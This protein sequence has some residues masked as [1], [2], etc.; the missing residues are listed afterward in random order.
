[1]HARTWTYVAIAAAA[2][3]TACRTGFRVARFTTNEALYAAGMREFGRQNW[4]NA[5]AAF[6]K[7]TTD[8]SPRDTLLPRSF[9]YLALAHDHQREH[10]LA[11]QAFTRLL[12]SFPEDTLSDDAALL[13]GRQYKRLWRKPSLDATY[14]ETALAAYNTVIGL[15]PDSEHAETARREI[16]EL[17]QWF[18]TKDYENG[19][20]YYRRKAWDSA[21]IYFRSVITRWPHVPR[22]RDALL[23]MAEANQRIRY[24]EDYVEACTKLRQSYPGDAEVARVCQDAPAV[25]VPTDSTARARPV[26]GD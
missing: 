6:E 1:M 18:A 13:A 12:E 5:I 3:L 19:M 23:R 16:A 4:G 14:G 21:L 9:W 8:L 25:P 15:Y 22:A 20:Y 2:A 17:E 24:R 11:A 10:L 26:P 7:L